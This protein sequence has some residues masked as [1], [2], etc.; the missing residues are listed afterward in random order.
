MATRKY[1][2][3]A[4]ALLSAAGCSN[5]GPSR[6]NTLVLATTTSVRDTGLLDALL[7]PFEHAQRVDV[8]VIAVGSG[9]AL[10]YGRRGD[11]DAL[12]THAPALEEQFVAEGLGVDRRQFM[13]NDFVLIGPADDPAGVGGGHDA[14]AAMKTIAEKQATFVSRGDESGTHVMENSLWERAGAKPAAPWYIEAGTGMAAT[15]R[16]AHEKRAYAL[17]DRGTYLTLRSELELP[18]L[19][20]GDDAL[21]NVYSIMVVNS[22]KHPH[23]NSKGAKALVEHLTSP[24]AQDAIAEFGLK[25]FGEPIFIPLRPHADQTP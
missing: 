10:A 18:I 6:P 16:M 23:V 25:T 11:A 3:L 5:N 4:A 1:G 24:A 17:T 15:L 20:E 22:A 14:A 7:P 9:Q 21:N 12:L 2:L 19:V 8:K 13:R